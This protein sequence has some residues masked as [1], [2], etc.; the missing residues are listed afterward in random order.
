MAYRDDESP[1]PSSGSSR[2]IF[3]T[4]FALASVV[5]GVVAAI[6]LSKGQ[7]WIAFVMAVAMFGLI[8]L[9]LRQ[10]RKFNAID[11][12]Y[13]ARRRWSA[14]YGLGAALFIILPT[15]LV[16]RHLDW[17]PMDWQSLITKIL[18]H[19]EAF[20]GGVFFAY[21]TIL[22]CRIAA[23]GIWKLRHQ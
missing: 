20:A 19:P 7:L 15:W 6:G 16:L 9:V 22:V 10:S 2:A 8:V 3:L 14:S 23:S 13:I 17:L 21:L 1:E 5:C 11:E 18:P 12:F 4:G